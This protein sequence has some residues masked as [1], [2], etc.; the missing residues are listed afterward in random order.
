MAGVQSKNKKTEKYNNSNC[1][2]RWVL[3]KSL[4]LL[5]VSFSSIFTSPTGKSWELMSPQKAHYNTHANTR[6]SMIIIPTFC[7]TAAILSSCCFF[8]SILS[9][10]RCCCTFANSKMRSFSSSIKRRSC[11]F[12]SA[13]FVLN[14]S[15]YRWVAN[16][17]CSLF[18]SSLVTLTMNS[19]K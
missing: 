11:A 9:S 7:C 5:E 3:I 10:S 12:H 13:R 4:P 1:G 8:F 18:S 2:P 19:F 15:M 17:F 16:C 6:H 14:S